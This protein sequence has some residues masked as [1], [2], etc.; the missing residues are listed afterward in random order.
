MVCQLQGSTIAIITAHVPGL[1]MWVSAGQGPSSSS[2]KQCK[3]D[4]LVK[5]YNSV[6][7]DE[8]ATDEIQEKKIIESTAI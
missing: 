1:H 2:P 6:A 8:I 7:T 5:I 3:L 4:S